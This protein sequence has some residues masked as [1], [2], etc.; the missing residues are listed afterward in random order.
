MK[1]STSA[2][3][4]T[5]V[6][7]LAIIVPVQAQVLEEI[8]V[9]AQKRE[10]SVQDVPISISAFSEEFV[11]SSGMT[12]VTDI[13]KFVPGMGFQSDGPTQTVLSIRGIGTSAFSASAD[14]SVGVFLDDVYSGHPLTSAQSFFDVERIEVI[15]GPQG[16]LFGRNTSA[17]AIS[18]TSKKADR[19]ASYAD[20]QVGAGNK[21]Q[22][23][24][25][26]IGNYSPDEDWG[27]RLGV[28]YEER[29]GTHKNITDNTELNSKDDLMVRLG[30]QNDWSDRFRSQ[31]LIQFGSSGAYYGVV[32]IDPADRIGG[33]K[34]ESVEQNTRNDQ[35]VSSL[36]AA[37]RLEYDVSDSL[38]LTS[39]SSYFDSEAIGI[40]FDADTFT[41]RVLEFEEPAD[42]EYLS[43][44]F[45]LNGAS[46]NFD[47]FVGASFRTEEVS[48]NTQL[49]YSDFDAIDILL[50][51]PCTNFEPD[52]GTCNLNV[53]EPSIAVAEN[54]SWGVYGDFTWHATGRLDVTVGARF[55]ND[56][57]DMAQNTPWQGA[58]S[59]TASLL[60]DNL[61]ELATAGVLVASED[62]SDFSPRLAV[63]YSVMDGFM[64]Y[65]N[66]SKGYKAGG[67][68]S[69]P[70]RPI[71]S[72]GPGDSQTVLAFEPEESLA[73]EIGFK[74]TLADQRL[75]LNGALFFIDYQD[76]QVETFKGLSFAIDNVSDAESKGL[77][78]EA[79]WLATENLELMLSYSYLDAE[80][81][82]GSIADPD[83]PGGSV[84]ISG[85]TMFNA[86]ENAFS[87]TAFYSQPMDWGSVDLRLG[88]SFMDDQLLADYLLAGD[89]FFFID[90][91]DVWD[92]RIAATDDD[93]RWSVALI[94]ENIG[95]ERWFTQLRDPAGI[96]QG[97]PN[98]G[99]L[100][101]LELSYRLN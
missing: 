39:I 83:L 48:V 54:D 74:S 21:G 7:A 97:V 4:V 59:V 51:E 62:W 70:D 5:A 8:V 20:F 45:R 100:Y 89:S 49:R 57:K 25:Q 69:S 64:I 29:D 81:K 53:V 22:G 94:G 80:L 26:A 99:D 68:N 60:D 12:N 87:A 84:D 13:V 58:N 42:F 63:N 52:F 34:T 36:R 19:D 90:S 73:Y 78:L 6:S 32:P 16:T 77:E 92:I 44:E 95:D 98:I 43:Q 86:P 41:A 47:W 1:A 9:T 46:E 17:G 96:T 40:P 85:K 28:K 75:R 18:V 91:H 15:K 67:F 2:L 101:R 24:Y 10:Q 72:L 65:A 33:L 50:G 55:S 27:V 79:Q 35:D 66:A 56:E 76:L 31:V 61:L 30:I 93:Q 82:N 38:M 14:S 23:I 71:S 88:Y 37:L 11:A 3:L